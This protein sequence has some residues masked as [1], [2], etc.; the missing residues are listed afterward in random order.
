MAAIELFCEM[1]YT[2]TDK[3]TA[4]HQG[5]YGRS[6]CVEQ[7]RPS[8]CS[9]SSTDW[10][11]ITFL[12]FI[13]FWHLTS[14]FW[15]KS[16]FCFV[17]L[18]W[19]QSGIFCRETERKKGFEQKLRKKRLVSLCRCVLLGRP[20]LFFSRRF[21]SNSLRCWHV[22]HVGRLH[23]RPVHP[24]QNAQHGSVTLLA[25]AGHVQDQA[26]VSALDL[27]AC[28]SVVLHT[29]LICEKDQLWNGKLLFPSLTGWNR[30]RVPLTTRLMNRG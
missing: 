13:T 27:F 16:L 12:G 6:D 3:G 14:N 24:Q 10:R 11:F 28:G 18:F 1:L 29:L 4:V 19:C 20:R 23:Q 22:K 7:T 8:P 15:Q 5:M 2:P 30:S 21:I 17:C 26:W 9:E 25:F